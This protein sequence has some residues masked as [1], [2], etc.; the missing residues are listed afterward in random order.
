MTEVRAS[1]LSVLTGGNLSAV[2]TKSL[3]GSLEF[4]ADLRLR[5][6]W[7]GSGPLSP[8]GRGEDGRILNLAAAKELVTRT[9][10][11][12]HHSPQAVVSCCYS[13]AKP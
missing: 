8:S 11:S 10:G 3:P 13:R 7:D 1:Q 5:E 9:S 4:G 2:K 12:C 6:T